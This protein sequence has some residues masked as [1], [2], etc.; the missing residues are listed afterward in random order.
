MKAF[1]QYLF[2]TLVTLQ[3]FM[4]ADENLFSSMSTWFS[5]NLST[6]GISVGVGATFTALNWFMIKHN[7]KA[8]EKKLESQCNTCIEKKLD[9]QNKR[10]TFLQLEQDGLKS[11][12]ALI[13]RQEFNEQVDRRVKE[14]LQPWHASSNEWKDSMNDRMRDLF[15]MQKLY[16]QNIDM[17]LMAIQHQTTLGK[18]FNGQQLR[19]LNNNFKGQPSDLS[20]SSPQ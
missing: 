18:L 19:P 2:I 1:K 12:P 14:Q 17:Q 13:S 6:I 8:L 7:N 9:E 5:K 4:H 20:S 3:P 16:Q 10:I 15:K 11:N